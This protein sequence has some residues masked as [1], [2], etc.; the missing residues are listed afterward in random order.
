MQTE[1]EQEII[2]Y[3]E[4]LDIKEEK[5]RLETYLLQLFL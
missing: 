3:I 1:W 5:T 2:L 4:R